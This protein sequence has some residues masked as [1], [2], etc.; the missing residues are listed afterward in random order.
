MERLPHNTAVLVHSQRL[1]YYALSTFVPQFQ[2]SFRGARHVE[3]EDGHHAGFANV[4]QEARSTDN[5]PQTGVV[6]R[7]N[8]DL[9]AEVDAVCLIS[10]ASTFTTLTIQIVIILTV[11]TITISTFE[12]TFT[13]TTNS[14]GNAKMDITAQDIFFNADQS[15]ICDD[16]TLEAE[17]INCPDTGCD[18]G[19]TA[20]VSFTLAFERLCRSCT[21]LRS[22]RKTI[23]GELSLQNRICL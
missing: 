12:T 3:Q 7:G 15:D 5:M 13:V 17:Q 9:Q 18:V 8:R 4:L 11:E 10:G 6:L 14:I 20:S 1:G 21:M 2:V 22:D 23:S 16:C 19:L